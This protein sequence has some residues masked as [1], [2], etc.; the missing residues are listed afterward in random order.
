MSKT[1]EVGFEQEV[2]ELLDRTKESIVGRVIKE[3]RR[4]RVGSSDEYRI[5][6]SD[7][8][9]LMMEMG[10]LEQEDSFGPHVWTSYA[11]DLARRYI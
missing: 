9:S 7:E 1:T 4:H 10:L 8:T 3:V 11:R 5:C 6:H 2:A